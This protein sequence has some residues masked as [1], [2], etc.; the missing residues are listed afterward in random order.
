MIPR[1][2]PCQSVCARQP[3]GPGH[4]SR[5]LARALPT[6]AAL[7]ALL[8]SAAQS[9]ATA[10]VGFTTS[11]RPLTVNVPTTRL[12]QLGAL[13]KPSLSLV[14]VASEVLVVIGLLVALIVLRRGPRHASDLT[15]A[16]R[17]GDVAGRA[18]AKA[19]KSAAKKAADHSAKNSGRSSAG[20]SILDEPKPR[21]KAAGGT[22]R[23]AAHQPTPPAG[24]PSPSPAP[25]NGSQRRGTARERRARRGNAPKRSAARAAVETR[26]DQA[27]VHE[28]RTR[29]DL[30]VVRLAARSD[31]VTWDAAHVERPTE[32]PADAVFVCVGAGEKGCLLVDLAAAPGTVAVRGRPAS[33]ARLARSIV[34]QL[35]AG[36]MADRATVTVVGDVSLEVDPPPGVNYADDLDHV[37]RR[38]PAG[39]PGRAE[40]VVF[41]AGKPDDLGQLTRLLT[42][43]D[44]KVI[45][46]A[47]GDAPDALW[48]FTARE[49]V[50][51]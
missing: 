47:I 51:A 38:A 1:H 5:G 46:L 17:A 3:R 18:G 20:M 7:G 36:S 32:R 40:L 2:S 28:V 44:R 10:N 14:V 48:S 12:H 37:A 11:A 26:V 31:R 27:R 13:I 4:R 35:A 33:R 50:P 41:R 9:T 42:D 15:R 8:A 25:A 34:R 30:V 49:P 22:T 19:T 16:T 6:A 21:A 39:A 23:P 45:P 24:R 29:D 43:P